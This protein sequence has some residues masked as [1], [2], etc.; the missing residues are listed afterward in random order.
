MSAKLTEADLMKLT[1]VIMAAIG[2]VIRE[3]LD[4]LHEKVDEAFVKITELRTELRCYKE[5]AGVPTRPAAP[6]G[7]VTKVA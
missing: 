5:A 1:D 3:E 4:Q 6:R 7:V 2:P